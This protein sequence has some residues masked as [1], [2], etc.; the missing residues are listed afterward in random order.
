MIGV[1][2]KTGRVVAQSRSL[3]IYPL[4]SPQFKFIHYPPPALTSTDASNE[5]RQ[6]SPEKTHLSG[7]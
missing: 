7:A 2:N 3:K 5:Q 4:S 1:P 6:Q